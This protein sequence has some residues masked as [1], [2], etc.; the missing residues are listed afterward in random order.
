LKRCRIF[1]SIL[2]GCTPTVFQSYEVYFSPPS[3]S[4]SLLALSVFC[5]LRGRVPQSSAPFAT[6]SLFFLNSFPSPPAKKK[7]F[8]HGCGPG[9]YNWMKDS[10]F[11][12]QVLQEAF[13]YRPLL[14]FKEYETSPFFL[15]K[16]FF[17]RL[18]PFSSRLFPTFRA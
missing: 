18:P 14:M 3:F 11:V 1:F 9:S 12:A 6:R 16:G 7:L 8:M 13:R 5:S 17:E 4:L 2:S 10:P 15:Q